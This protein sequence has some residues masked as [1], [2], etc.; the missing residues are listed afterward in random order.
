MD[1]APIESLPVQSQPAT[2]YRRAPLACVRGLGAVA[3]VFI[4]CAGCS[5]LLG[6]A[7]TVRDA[8]V[9]LQDGNAP[10]DA[11]PLCESAADCRGN[12]P[13][14]DASGRCVD[15]DVD[16][17]GFAAGEASCDAVRGEAPVDCD[18]ARDD[19]H[20]GAPVVC[21]DGVINGCSGPAEDV[22]RG[23]GVE[24]I[25]V[26]P[27]ATLHL[28]PPVVLLDIP[29]VVTLP[30]TDSPNAAVA[31]RAVDESG[32]SVAWILP[33]D[34]ASPAPLLA[35]V[36][37]T[38]LDRELLRGS[39]S[40]VGVAAST[41]TSATLVVQGTVTC[42]SSVRSRRGGRAPRYHPSIPT[43]RRARS[44]RSFEE[45][46][47]RVA[48][49]MCSLVSMSIGL[50]T[51]STRSTPQARSIASRTSAPRASRSVRT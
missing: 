7:P 1:D 19:V 51:R 11:M 46:G 42:P 37:I 32:S 4:L 45:L 47:R 29:T 34:H 13:V 40:A 44:R 6:P 31:V 41:L 25:G 20:P 22:A 2:K 24:E 14:C 21:G 33:F 50:C 48:T 27:P 17:D 30:P 26:L 5:L 15:C 16:G 39:I 3:P 10:V 49:G 18:D 12:L 36:T 9:V 8:G 28:A 43:G 35:P 38:A 23:L